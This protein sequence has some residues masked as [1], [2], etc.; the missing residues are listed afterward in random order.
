MKTKVPKS[1]KQYVRGIIHNLSLQHW[2]DQQI[3]D[4]LNNEKQI[5]ISRSRVTQIRRGTEKQAEK[6]YFEL[7]ESRYK[8]VAM[9]KERIDSLFSY[10]KKLHEIINSEEKAE[11]RI[12]AITELHAIEV[13]LFSM[14]KQLPNLY[15]NNSIAVNYV[16]VAAAAESEGE[17]KG[18]ESTQIP[19]VDYPDERMRFDK[20]TLEGKPMSAKYIMEMKSKY[21]ISDSHAASYLKQCTDCKRWFESESFKVNHMCI[22]REREMG[23]LWR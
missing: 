10:Q 4:F 12:R 13:T 14:W 2:S 3:M 9:F 6:W 22:E 21:G 16:P 1:E 5:M 7:R 20:W 8:Y 11:I 19:P 18:Y 23:R 17:E 15:V